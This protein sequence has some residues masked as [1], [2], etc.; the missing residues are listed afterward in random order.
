MCREEEVWRRL[1]TLSG[2]KWNT[3]GWPNVHLEF[4]VASD[5]KIEII[6]W[7][8]QYIDT[9]KLGCPETVMNYV[10]QPPRCQGKCR[11]WRMGVWEVGRGQ[12][13]STEFF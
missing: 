11:D 9:W 1:K 7:I 5:G 10:D 3:L 13:L 4:L 12:M 6:S 2:K 8:T